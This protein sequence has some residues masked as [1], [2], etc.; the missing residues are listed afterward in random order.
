ME[1]E[2]SIHEM[3]ATLGIEARPATGMHKEL[4]RVATGESIGFFTASEALKYYHANKPDA[5]GLKAMF[6]AVPP[7]GD[8]DELAAQRKAGAE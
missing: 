1:K 8:L 6:D 5:S 2:P 4:V 3:L 7:V